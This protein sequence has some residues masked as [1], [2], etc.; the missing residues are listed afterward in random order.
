[1]SAALVLRRP[2]A[3]DAAAMS[4][5]LT[6]SIRDLCRADHGDDPERLAAWLDGKSPDR[7]AEWIAAGRVRLLVAERAGALVGVGGWAPHGDEICGRVMLLY[8]APAHR[9]SGVSAALLARMEAEMAAAG[10][11]RATLTSTRAA[12]AF[13]RARGWRDDGPREPDRS[14]GGQPMARA[15]AAPDAW[16]CRGANSR[17]ASPRAPPPA[18]TLS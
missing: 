12:H 14:G 18:Q 13:Y 7:V 10:L 15:L 17:R 11:R 16:A 5:V 8:V 4:A 9:L 3:A 2:A 6:A 1:V